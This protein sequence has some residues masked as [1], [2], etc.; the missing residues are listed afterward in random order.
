[1]KP[2]LLVIGSE[3]I[4]GYDFMMALAV[5]LGSIMV[6]Y[7][8]K[9][10]GIHLAKVIPFL[11]LFVMVSLMGAK[12]YLV[13]HT[14]L[15]DPMSMVKNPHEIFNILGSG[16]VFYGG[17]LAA[18]FFS[19]WYL[20]KIGLSFWRLM[21]IM[22]VGAA[23]GHALGRIGCFLAG[24]CYGIPTN[25]FLAVKFPHLPVPVHPTQ[26]YASILNFIN[27]IIL[28]RFFKK[29]KFHGHVAAFYLMNYAVIRFVVEYFR[30]DFG[31]GYLVR[32]PSTLMRLSIPQFIS[33]LLFLAG[34]LVYWIKK[35]K[36]KPR[37]QSPE[38]IA[39][40]LPVVEVQ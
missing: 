3:V 28:L 39:G 19:A 7:L 5:I 21:D 20:R 25:F 17:F 15:T 6:I 12:L 23:I 2:V 13:I 27:F 30:G 26:L 32:G 1:M 4:S 35:R 8:A 29:R 18:I 24:C 38:Q 34:I 22:A 9:K 31:R 14:F 10:D 40:T 33:L 11:V 37:H 16:G 36:E